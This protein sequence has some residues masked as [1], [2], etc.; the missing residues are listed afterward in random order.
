MM[1]KKSV[2][3]GDILEAGDLS[4]FF[5]VLSAENPNSIRGFRIPEKTHY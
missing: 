5:V 1:P 3:A 4:S 2:E